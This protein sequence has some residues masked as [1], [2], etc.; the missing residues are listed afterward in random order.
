M[1][2][3]LRGIGSCEYDGW[4]VPWQ[5][6][7]RAGDSGRLMMW[8]NLSVKVSKP[9]KSMEWFSFP[10][11]KAEYQEGGHSVP[12][13]LESKPWRV[14]GPYVQGRRWASPSAQ[15]GQSC[16][17]FSRPAAC[18]WCCLSSVV[19]S[20][21]TDVL[22]SSGNSLINTPKRTLFQVSWFFFYSICFWHLKLIITLWKF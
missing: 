21:Q 18:W 16:I 5:L 4:E 9:G 13:V 20:T 15:R 2:W 10:D 3:F 12:Y 6:P 1:N 11:T 8:L 19:L 14:W 7:C 17:D 22:I